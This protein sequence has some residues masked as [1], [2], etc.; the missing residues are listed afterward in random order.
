MLLRMLQ[1]LA[2]LPLQ[3]GQTTQVLGGDRGKLSSSGGVGFFPSQHCAVELDV[4]AEQRAPLLRLEARITG[5][6]LN[7]AALIVLPSR[8]PG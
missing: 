3:I 4:I 6:V 2:P 8:K 5:L 7:A 1:P